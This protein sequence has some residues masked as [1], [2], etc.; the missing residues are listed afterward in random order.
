MMRTTLRWGLELIL[1]LALVFTA[2]WL[3]TRFVAMP[4]VVAGDSM[5]P[6][7]EHG[8][9]VIVD[10]W[11]YRGRPP[12]SGEIALFDGPRG[13]PMVKRVA[14]LPH[15]EHVR[16]EWFGPSGALRSGLWVVGDNSDASRDSRRFGTVPPDRFRGRL[17]WRYWPVSKAGPLR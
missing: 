11:S 3:V 2:V 4:W 13:V 1:A 12:R 8:D 7:L 15:L 16:S 10:L 17:V 5:S 14:D 9:R 6:T